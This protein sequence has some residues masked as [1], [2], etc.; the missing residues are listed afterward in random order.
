[1]SGL[2][3][4]GYDSETN[5]D[6]DMESVDGEDL[7]EGEIKQGLE[8]QECGQ[9]DDQL[10]GRPVVSPIKDQLD[11]QPESSPVNNDGHVTGNNESPGGQPSTGINACGES[12][13]LHG[14]SFVA[15]HG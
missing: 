11:G 9:E 6:S 14:D 12:Q 4:Q 7:E 5:T 10:G 2:G 8:N 13:R 15:A 1:M 3:S